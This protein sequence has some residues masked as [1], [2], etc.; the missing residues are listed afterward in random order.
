MP[1]GNSCLHEFSARSTRPR[2]CVP[3][4]SIR[5]GMLS[6]PKWVQQVTYDSY[7]RRRPQIKWGHSVCLVSAY[8][9]RCRKRFYSLLL[10][11]LTSMAARALAAANASRL[12]PCCARHRKHYT[13]T[14]LSTAQP[15]ITPY[16]CRN[17][18]TDSPPCC[19]L[20]NRNHPL[21]GPQPRTSRGARTKRTE[22][23]H[24]CPPGQVF[25]VPHLRLPRR[26]SRLGVWGR[27]R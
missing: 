11:P 5:G 7:R 13:S 25:P 26:S 2:A 3:C 1:R 22:G 9:R 17:A 23:K 16:A 15:C 14:I 27:L 10:G 12:R 4:I 20:H 6:R 18:A 21:L 8:Y 24:P 19:H